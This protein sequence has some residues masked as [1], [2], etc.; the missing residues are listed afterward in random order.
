MYRHLS[1]FGSIVS[2][3]D[4]LIDDLIDSISSP[5]MSTLLT[6]LSVDK[7]FSFESSSRAENAGS[8]TEGSHIK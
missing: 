7:I 2:V 5:V 1:S 8:L 3:T 4:A 6:I